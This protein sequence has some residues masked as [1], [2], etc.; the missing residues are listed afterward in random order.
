MNL[1]VATEL[2]S[3]V[4]LADWMVAVKALWMVVHSD[5]MMV[6]MTVDMREIWLAC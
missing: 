1:V 3:A 4:E 6:G 2:C 5:V